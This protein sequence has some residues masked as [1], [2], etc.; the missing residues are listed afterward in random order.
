LIFPNLPNFW[1]LKLSG[2][3]PLYSGGRV[4]AEITAAEHTVLASNHELESQTDNLELQVTSIYWQLVLAIE[5]ERILAESIQSF[6]AH[7]VDALNRQEVGLVASNEPLAVQTERDRAEL[8]RLLAASAVRNTQ[9]QLAVLIGLPI[10]TRV[11]PTDEL[12]PGA[13]PPQSVEDLVALAKQQRPERKAL[14]QRIASGEAKL[15]A[16]N[17]VRGPNIGITGSVSYLNPDRRV[18]PPRDEFRFAWDIGI[19]LQYFIFDGGTRKAAAGAA[20]AELDAT[21]QRL[22]E[23][24]RAIRNQVVESHESLQTALAAITVAEQAVRSAR[25]NLRVTR[26]LYLEGLI[27]SS[28]RLDAQVAELLAGLELTESR[29]QVQL[30]RASLRRALGGS[31][32]PASGVQTLIGEDS[33][34]RK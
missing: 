31:G 15:E 23:L 14:E 3:I 5:Q 19:G 16:A 34:S 1:N 2:L 4:P 11:L 24:D 21:R 25:E 26:D 8:R 29:I 22:Q 17:S 6:E 30:A 27:P 28:E 9:D 18:V 12:S 32:T 10:G 20:L 13:A 7:L 33:L